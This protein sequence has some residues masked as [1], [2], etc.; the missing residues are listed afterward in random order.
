MRSRKIENIGNAAMIIVWD[1]SNLSV[2]VYIDKPMR[3][4]VQVLQGK[5]GWDKSGGLVVDYLCIHRTL[6]SACQYTTVVVKKTCI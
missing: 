2:Y 4:Y 6:K 5:Q 1:M 3:S